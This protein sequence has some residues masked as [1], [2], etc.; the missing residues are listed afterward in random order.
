MQLRGSHI[1]DAK[2]ASVWQVLMNPDLLAKVVPGVTRLETL[3]ENNFKSILTVKVGPV[4]GSFSGNLQLE[5][6]DPEKSFTLTAKQNSNIGNANAIVKININMVDDKQTEL[7]FDGDVK[8][9]GM[10]AT[11]GQRVVGGVANTITKQF[12]T[13]LET[14]LAAATNHS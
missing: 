3:S 14:E 12:F 4:S 11:M 1:F 13:N 5:N 10:L 9:S 6:I 7:V 8:L 2:A